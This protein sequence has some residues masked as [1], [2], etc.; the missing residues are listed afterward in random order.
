MKIYVGTYQKY[1]NGSLFGKWLDLEDYVDLDDFFEACQELHKDEDD[2][3]LMF[4]DFED[5]P[6]AL[7][8]ESWITEDIFDYINFDGDRDALDAFMTLGHYSSLAD[9]LDAFEDAF[10]GTL[11][12]SGSD[13]CNLAY[14]AEENGMIDIPENMQCYFDYEAFGR[15]LSYDYDVV[16]DFIFANN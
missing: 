9:Y 10:M 6:D 16:D 1:N 13:N 12:G 15:D 3:E 4:Q 5:I 2:P 11:D 14:W 8:D 7:I